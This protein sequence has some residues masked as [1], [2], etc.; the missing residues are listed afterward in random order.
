MLKGFFSCAAFLF[1]VLMAQPAEAGSKYGKYL[2]ACN[3]FKSGDDYVQRSV[4]YCLKSGN[5]SMCERSARQYYEVCGFG[6]AEQYTEVSEQVYR[7]LLKVVVLVD[8]SKRF[9]K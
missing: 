1:L 5:P 6:S 9:S 4:M 8:T 3:S 2:S 7:R